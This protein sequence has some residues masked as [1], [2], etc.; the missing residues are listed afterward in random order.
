MTE[1]STGKA[2]K[3][4]PRLDLDGVEWK[5]AIAAWLGVIYLV[6]WFSIRGADQADPASPQAASTPRD[7]GISDKPQSVS[8]AGR[9]AASP[10]RARPARLR[11]RSS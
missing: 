10:G 2:G 5:A 7:E 1:R 8:N 3:A 4:G 9:P 6:S 11:T